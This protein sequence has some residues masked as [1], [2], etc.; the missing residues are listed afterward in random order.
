MV[1]G[2]YGMNFDHMP[3][4]HYRFGYPLVLVATLSVCMLLYR[5]FKAAG[6]L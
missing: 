3:E 6:W 2:L 4:L 1:F 5:R